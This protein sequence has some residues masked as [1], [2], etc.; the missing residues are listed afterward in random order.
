METVESGSRR[1]ATFAKRAKKSFSAPISTISGNRRP[2]SRRIGRARIVSELPLTANDPVMICSAPTIWPMRMMV[3]SLSV[4]TAGTRR[5]SNARNRSSRDS[6]CAPSAI[7]SSVRADTEPSASQLNR[8]SR[9]AFS[10]GMTSCLAPTATSD[11]AWALVAMQNA[12][13]KM[14]TATGPISPHVHL[15]FCILNFVMPP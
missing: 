10:N 9:V 5:C 11:C 2:V 15:A 8:G 6:A 3:A 12:K 14:Q 13:V 4:D 7:R 1:R